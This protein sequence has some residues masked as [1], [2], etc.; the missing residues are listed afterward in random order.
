MDDDRS[1]PATKGDFLDLKQEF[2]GDL[3]E[4]GQKFSGQLSGLKDELVEAIRDGQT[5]V[6][7]AF[8]GFSQTVLD[9]FKEQ[10]QTE[11]GLKRRMATIESRIFEI[12]KRL[13]MPP[14]GV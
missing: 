14:S 7:R 2:K 11:A 8:Y 9:R 6:L 12:E 1:Q 4:L 10:D 13:N 5:E 3:L